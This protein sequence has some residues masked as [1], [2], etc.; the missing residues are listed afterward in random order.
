MLVKSTNLRVSQQARKGHKSR[1]EKGSMRPPKIINQVIYMTSY[2]M[3]F[4][5]NANINTTVRWQDVLST[6]FVAS[7]TT[8]GYYLFA[9]VRIKSLEAWSVPTTGVTA[10]G[11]V[12]TISLGFRSATAGASGNQQMVTDTGFLGEPAHVYLKAPK[13][14]DSSLWQVASSNAAFDVVIPTGGILDVV[15]DLRSYPGAANT[16]ANVGVGMTVG[17]TYARGLDGV[18]V[19]TSIWIPVYEA[20]A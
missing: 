1:K 20:I 15:V 14:V 9:G 2:R 19:A 10:P 4:I 12:S 8:V 5:A 3:R 13:N 17:A 7:S 16:L 18:A 6:R 11:Q